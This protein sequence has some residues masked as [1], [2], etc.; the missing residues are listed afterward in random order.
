M[1]RMKVAAGVVAALI[2]VPVLGLGGFYGWAS[3]TTSGKMDR[4]FKVHD[5]DFP[6]P[7]PLSDAEL[8]QLRTERAALLPPTEALVDPA[9]ALVATPDP[10]VGVDLNAIAAERAVVRGKHLVEARY[11]CGECHGANFGGGKMVD[12]PIV[13]H[14]LGA[15]L[16]LGK[17][18]RTLDYKPADWDHT[19][20]H[21]VKPDGHPTVMPAKDFFAMSDHEL[22]DIVMY[23]RSLPPVDSTV[24]PV[25]FGPLLKVLVAT[26]AAELSV[27]VHPT[28]HEGAHVVEPPPE[29]PDAA[30]GAHIMKACTGCHRADFS[31]GPIAGG[32]PDWPPAANL[33]PK[34]VGDW[35]FEDFQRALRDAKKPDGTE[36]KQPMKDMTRLAANM[37]DVELQAMWAYLQTLP[38]TETGQ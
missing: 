6:I 38:P 37:S 11:A 13:G 15:N 1:N 9:G 4:T 19:V 33:T 7:F 28:N 32:P 12:D 8:A 27:D 14:M 2:G 17:G 29:A 21:G 16:T 24:D 35:K 20:R 5:V 31:G 26:G 34:G 22:S 23:I 25:A 3:I 18:S 30:F 36:L 10:L